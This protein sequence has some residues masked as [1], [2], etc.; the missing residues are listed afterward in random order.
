MRFNFQLIFLLICLIV[1]TPIDAKNKKKKKDNR[2]E[3]EI[4]QETELY[5]EAAKA[6]ILGDFN[7][8]VNL[9]EGVVSL[10]ENNAAAQFEL[11]SLYL[12]TNKKEKAEIAAEK[13]MTLD[14]DNK[15][16][17]VLYTE[18]LANNGKFE[19]AASLYEKIVKEDPRNVES[20][21]EWA[22]M[23]LNANKL[24]EALGAYQQ[25]E[26]IVGLNEDIVMEKQ[27]IYLRLNDV[28]GAAS[29]IKRLIKE[30]PSEIKYSLLLGDL[31]LSNNRKNEA[32]TIYNELLIKDPSNP[33][34]SMALASLYKKDGDTANYNKIISK[35]IKDPKADIDAKIGFLFHGLQSFGNLSKE[36]KKQY[37]ELAKEL[38]KAHEKS[39]KVQALMG[40]FYNLNEEISKALISYKNSL[41]IQSDVFIVWQQLFSILLEE[42]KYQE[43]ADSSTRA[44]E[45]YP[46]QSIAYYFNG[47]ANYHLKNYDL[48]VKRLT[49][50]A[51]IAGDN[52][53]LKAQVYA[54]IGDIYHEQKR[55]EESDNAYEE[56]LTHDSKNAYTLNNYAYHLS[57]RGLKLEKAASMSKK[58]L[59]LDSKSSSFL[60][61]YAWILFKQENYKEAKIYQE[62]ALEIE[63]KDRTTL[64]E[65]YGDILYFLNDKE[66]AVEFWKK[67]QTAGN[68]S[69]TL[70]KKIG[71]KK[72]YA[73]ELP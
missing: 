31:Y 37:L 14:P 29:E 34:A 11:A 36:D 15:W 8:A 64:L 26:K 45:L 41:A 12:G 48:S 43:L 47:L 67:S 68:I 22:F 17:T 66:K 65:H 58:S 10:N 39:A 21:V 27:K 23:L 63:L 1:S 46:T 60:D 54:L 55:H 70:L 24:K 3:K 73:E 9:F 53:N 25:V 51:Q 59:E 20:Y 32:K 13:A 69:P 5:L 2:S 72:Y 28:D 61:T 50:S 52:S 7:R 33:Y 19:K 38:V 56:S 71:E 35:I 62:K 16:Y 40:D 4:L 49:K 42:K 57:V 18:I 30:F 44:I 6:K